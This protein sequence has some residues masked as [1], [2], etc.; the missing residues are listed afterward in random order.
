MSIL[1]YYKPPPHRKLAAY[2]SYLDSRTN[3]VVEIP[4][5]DFY[6]PVMMICGWGK[7]RPKKAH[8]EKQISGS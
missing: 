6:Y 4:C 7:E 5:Q 1:R 8:E 2:I 3:N